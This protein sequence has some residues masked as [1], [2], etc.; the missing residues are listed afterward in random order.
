MFVIAGEYNLDKKLGMVADRCTICG[1]V[2]LL[3][4]TKLARMDHAYFIPVSSRKQLGT[5]LVCSECKGK[6]VCSPQSF[7]CFLP[8]KEARSLSLNEVLLRTNPRLAESMNHR[9]RL[10]RESLGAP[11]VARKDGINPRV[12]LAFLKISCL[13][14]NDKRIVELQAKLAQWGALDSATQSRILSDVDTLAGEYER[15][16]A[17][18]HFLNF[19]AQRFKPEISGLP[20]L[21]SFVLP[22]IPGI[23]FTMIFLNGNETRMATGL[24]LSFVPALAVGLLANWY[25]LRQ[26]HKQFFRSVFLPEADER[27]LRMAP[28]IE[29]LGTVDT[30]D[31]RIDERHR[32]MARAIP[33]LKQVL[34][35]QNRYVEM[36]NELHD[37]KPEQI[38]ALHQ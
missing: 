23:A 2:T 6:S 9:A 32:G 30:D 24:A 10:E 17:S 19:V 36:T 20:K 26:M 14:G 8:E 1:S 25:F 31:L 11:E 29:L 18:E 3:S 4:A 13:S 15:R 35:E 12:E 28:V 34:A 37:S 27:G 22:L 7:A 16:E 5:V 38:D 21:M 33:L